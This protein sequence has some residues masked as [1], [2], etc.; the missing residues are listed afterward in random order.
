MWIFWTLQ[1]KSPSKKYISYC[2]ILLQ[3]KYISYFN[4][5]QNDFLGCYI[6]HKIFQ[7][8][9]TSLQGHVI[10]LILL[11][12]HLWL[13]LM[14]KTVVLLWCISFRILWWIERS[15]EQ[16]LFEMDT[17]CNIIN[18]FTITFAVLIASFWNIWTVVCLIKSSLRSWGSV[19]HHN[20]HCCV[21]QICPDHLK[22]FRSCA[23]VLESSLHS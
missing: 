18:D 16:C 19:W 10:L 20:I 17:F 4:I 6:L 8:Q 14:L 1:F 22:V 12:K 11:K 9:Y 13:W 21:D 7:H 5:L 2:K 3:F 23:V 15:K